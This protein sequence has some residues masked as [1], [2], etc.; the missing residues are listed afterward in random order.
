MTPVMPVTALILIL[1]LTL[2]PEGLRS[3]KNP[4][5]QGLQQKAKGAEKFFS[6]LQLEHVSGFDERVAA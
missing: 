2:P 3:G 1:M 6:I 5:R 4:L